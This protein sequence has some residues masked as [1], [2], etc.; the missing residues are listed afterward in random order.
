[1]CHG[2]EFFTMDDCAQ[3]TDLSRGNAPSSLWVIGLAVACPCHAP[4]TAG[5]LA[6][7]GVGT[8]TSGLVL[9]LTGIL[10]FIFLVL[11]VALLVWMVRSRDRQVELEQHKEAQ[12]PKRT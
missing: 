12:H 4:I 9:G 2:D 8:L 3:C 7:L 10:S 5:V 11:A 6:A 1:M